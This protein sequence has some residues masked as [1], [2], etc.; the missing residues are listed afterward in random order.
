MVQN[1]KIDIIYYDTPSDFEF[2]FNLGGCC[3]SRILNAH[4]HQPKEMLSGL[5][6]AVGRSR[7]ILIIG[8]LHG[9][10]GLIDLVSKSVSIPLVNANTTEYAIIS[11]EEPMILSGSLPL[12]SKDGVLS[13]C[14]VE[15]GPQSI[16]LLPNNKALR[17]DICDNLVFPYIT[18]L[19]RIPETDNVIQPEE[20]KEENI[21]PDN[22]DTNILEAEDSEEVSL[23]A[24]VTAE[25]SEENETT[26]NNSEEDVSE[27]VFPKEE[28][29]VIFSGEKISFD[30]EENAD[31]ISINDSYIIANEAGAIEP[32]DNN[33]YF[34]EEQKNKKR[35]RLS[36]L[37]V[38][39]LI[40]CGL[41]LV[42]AGLLLYL[43]VYEPMANSVEVSDYIKEF[44]K[45]L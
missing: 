5:A 11:P 2:E 7:V 28:D 41:L 22:T 42:I 9:D 24:E 30:K 40:L 34:G 43:L 4:T 6:K 31:D 39:I 1:L 8:N 20:S 35:K 19:S 37:S 15:S 38:S 3:H 16:I 45:F 44:F 27:I 25:I 18:A 33:V 17:K 29:N 13:G 10:G 36:K 23:D 21:L 14:I 12:V 26:D 32:D